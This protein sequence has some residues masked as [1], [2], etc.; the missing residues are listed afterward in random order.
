MRLSDLVPDSGEDI[1]GA[2]AVRGQPRGGAGVSLR[3][4][5]GRAR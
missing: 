3:R 5:L 2:R 1:E 4:A